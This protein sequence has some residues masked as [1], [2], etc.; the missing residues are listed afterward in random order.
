VVRMWCEANVLRTSAVDKCPL[1]CTCVTSPAPT[2]RSYGRSR[3]PLWR[4]S[5][6]VQIPPPPPAL[7]G[8]STAKALVRGP[9]GRS[10]APLNADTSPAAFATYEGVASI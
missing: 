8:L 3:K 1:T 9:W 5:P 7:T 10:T 6:W 2:T 4:K